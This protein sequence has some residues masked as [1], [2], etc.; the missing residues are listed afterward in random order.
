MSDNSNSGFLKDIAAD[1]SAMVG[2][3][4]GNAFEDLTEYYVSNNGYTRLFTATRY[5]KRYVLKCLKQEYL[6]SPFHVQALQKEFEIGI[7]L[8]HQYICRTLGIE[9]MDDL[10]ICIVMEYVDGATLRRLMGQGSID[11]RT[12]RR[13]VEQLAKAMD[14]L[15]NKQIVHR[16]LKPENIMLTHNGKNVKLID[17]SLSDSDVFVVLKMPAGSMGYIAPEQLESDKPTD[18]KADIYSYGVVAGD[19]ADCCHDSRLRDIF[20][21]CTA[22]DAASRPDS[23]EQLLEVLERNRRLRMWCYFLS[24]TALIV[25]CLM[26][27]SIAAYFRTLSSPA[28]PPVDTENII[29]EYDK[30]DEVGGGIR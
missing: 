20:R 22:A 26:C 25:F 4:Q 15:H 16:D 18:I 21:I 28:A 1:I 7:Q 9:T 2:M 27:L 17:F 14:Y 11:R 23:R 13:V 29:L 24:V 6:S 19:L 3:Q 5:G 8:D 12:A 30:W 10:G